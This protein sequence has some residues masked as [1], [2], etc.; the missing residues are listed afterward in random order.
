LDRRI[1]LRVPNKTARRKNM[2]VHIPIHPTLLAFLE[3]TA[4]SRRSG[5]VLPEH[6]ARYRNNDSDVAK[7]IRRHFIECGIQVH[8]DGTGYVRAPSR[9]MREKNVHTGT[10][11]V[12]EVGF[13]SLRHSFVS[14]CRQANAPLSVVEA[15]VGHSNPAM[16]RHYTHVGELAAAA[17]VGALPSLMDG[18]GAA[19]A[20]PAGESVGSGQAAV[21]SALAEQLKALA[22]RLNGKNWKAIQAEL[23][24]LAGA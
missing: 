5:Y 2:P 3:K 15:I 22:G 8:R 19:R 10:R 9:G 4:K 7:E 21:G 11:A 13:H 24:A 6:A 12:V 1:V 20:L 18:A 14:L 23:M 17:A 16:T